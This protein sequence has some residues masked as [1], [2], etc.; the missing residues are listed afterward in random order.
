MQCVKDSD[1]EEYIHYPLNRES[2][3]WAGRSLE[4]GLEWKVASELGF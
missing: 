2:G 4:E 3:S 1:E